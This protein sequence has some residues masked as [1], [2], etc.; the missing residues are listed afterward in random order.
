MKTERE[1]ERACKRLVFHF[2]RA[3]TVCRCACVYVSTKGKLLV[4]ATHRDI[5][6]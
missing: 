6:D 1:R 2:K 4:S 5:F 3:K